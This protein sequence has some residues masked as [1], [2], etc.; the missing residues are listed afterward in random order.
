MISSILMIPI[1]SYILRNIK[2]AGLSLIVIIVIY[3][4]LSISLEVDMDKRYLFYAERYNDKLDKMRMI[5]KGE[6]FKAYKP[7]IINSLIEQCNRQEPKCDKFQALF[8]PLR[9][10]ESSLIISLITIAFSVYLNKIEAQEIYYVVGGIISVVLFLLII[11]YSIASPIFDILN[12]KKTL[13][14]EMKNILIDI[15]IYDF[16]VNVNTNLF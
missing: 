7:V 8:T 16:N 6:P 13:M 3:T 12:K 9:T 10:V 5:L 1:S 4:Y 15:L 14:S 2:L 11:Y